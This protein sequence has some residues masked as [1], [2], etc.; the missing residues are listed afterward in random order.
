MF[1]FGRTNSAK[2]ARA[3]L[4]A[5]T[6]EEGGVGPP[7][8]ALTE[9]HDET[10]T[11]ATSELFFG[12][13]LQ[14]HAEE[15]G[16]GF[17]EYCWLEGKRFSDPG[18]FAKL[19]GVWGL[20]MPNLVIRLRSGDGP[21]PAAMVAEGDLRQPDIQAVPT[22]AHKLRQM[23]EKIAQSMPA[24]S[25]EP[26]APVDAESIANALADLGDD[27]QDKVTAIIVALL[28]A[29]AQTNS[30]LISLV[31]SDRRCCGNIPLRG[32]TG[33]NRCE[34]R[35]FRGMSRSAGFSDIPALNVYSGGPVASL[36]K[37]PCCFGLPGEALHAVKDSLRQK[38]FES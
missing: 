33:T 24:S 19:C 23:Q 37:A 12:R 15:L 25:S 30:W 2:N 34:T 36:S 5:T 11:H 16:Y 9:A 7:P 21:H 6:E 4:P 22:N 3:L 18:Q 31:I 10:L 17:Q 35:R 27:L 20:Q 29:C 14:P 32:C 8:P 38:R 13:V 1:S 26:T 28:E